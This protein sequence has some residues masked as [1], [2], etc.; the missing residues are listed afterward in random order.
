M[1]EKNKK[2]TLTG[3]GWAIIIVGVIFSI[4]ILFQRG[5]FSDILFS[6]VFSLIAT[7][8]LARVVSFLHRAFKEWKNE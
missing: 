1:T 7:W 2:A 5:T 4:S 8:L 3:C 6:F